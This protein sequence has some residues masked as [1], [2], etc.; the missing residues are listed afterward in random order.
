MALRDGTEN[1]DDCRAPRNGR[2]AF[3]AARPPK[4]ERSGKPIGMST[5]MT[6]GMCAA[7]T[8]EKFEMTATR[9]SS[10]CGRRKT[11]IHPARQPSNPASQTSV[12]SS[13]AS[14]VM[15]G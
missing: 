4:P 10:P 7:I 14:F 1:T 13:V 3:S 11:A 8:S 6:A 12:F 2:A 9:A 5:A 15:H